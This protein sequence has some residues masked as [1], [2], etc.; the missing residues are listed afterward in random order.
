MGHMFASGPGSQT[1]FKTS[2]IPESAANQLRGCRSN[3]MHAA[4]RPASAVRLFTNLFNSRKRTAGDM[5]R[6][7][8]AAAGEGRCYVRISMV[9]LM[10]VS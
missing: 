3:Q 6:A 5:L 9:V 1:A 7:L 4:T 8:S 10:T 2:H